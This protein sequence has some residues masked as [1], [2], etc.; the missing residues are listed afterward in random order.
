MDQFTLP[1]M[2]YV[3]YH[4]EIVVICHKTS[5]R[6]FYLFFSFAEREGGENV[7]FV[8]IFN[9]WQMPILMLSPLWQPLRVPGEEVCRASCRGS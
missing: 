8:L 1:M 4:Y 7:L 2:K 3:E 5:Q 9:L 6:L